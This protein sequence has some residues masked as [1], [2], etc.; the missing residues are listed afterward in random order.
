MVRAPV[1]PPSDFRQSLLETYAANE[2]MNQVL[3]DRLDPRA[4]MAKPPSRNIRTIAAIFAHMH[5]ARRKW[6]RLSAPHIKLPVEL[7]RRRCTRRQVQVALSRSARDCSKMLREALAPGGAVKFFHRDG[8][9]RPWPPGAAMFAYMV[10][11]DAHHRGQIC[12]LAHQLG[13]PIKASHEIWMWERLWKQCGFL[14][15]R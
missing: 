2:R 3:L 4:W 5:Q 14:G 1:L 10:T 6:L 7:D 8:W 11:H 9:S 12:M 13:F 15:P